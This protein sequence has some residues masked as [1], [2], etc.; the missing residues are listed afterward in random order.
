MVTHTSVNRNMSI[1]SDINH[2]KEYMNYKNIG[3]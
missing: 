3:C 2:G 1:L